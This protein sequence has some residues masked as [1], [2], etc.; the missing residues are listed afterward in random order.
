MYKVLSSMG[1]TSSEK[2]D[3]SS[4]QLREVAQMCY[5][6]WKEN[7]TVELGPIEWEEFKEAFLGKY[8]PHERREVKVQKF[9]NLK[10]GNMSIEEY[11]LKFSRLSIFSPSLVSNPRYEMSRFVTGLA[12]LVKEECHTTMQHDDMTLARLIV[13]AQSIEESKLGRIARNLNGVDEVIKF[14]LG[15]IRGIKLK[16]DIVLLRCNFRKVVVL[17][18]ASLH[19]ILMERGIMGSV[20]WVPGVVLDVIKNYIK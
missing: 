8:F 19:V 5:T 7:S 16:M 6:Q 3:F 10:Q 9:I 12:D 17:K 1:M 4:Y 15:S 20:C 13:Y 18:M 2:V 11:S 14:N